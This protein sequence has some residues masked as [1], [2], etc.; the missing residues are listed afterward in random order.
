[1]NEH[2]ET[3]TLKKSTIWKAG[4][5]VFAILFVISLFTGGFGLGRTSTV[6][7]GAIVNPPAAAPAP[8]P[9]PAA[10]VNAADFV[11]DDP[12]LGKENA[13]VTIVEFS[14][15][16]CPFCSRFR[17][18]TFDQIKSQYIDTGKVRF[19]Y[20]DFPLT[21]IHPQAQK[22]AEASECADEQGKF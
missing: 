6:T 10:N 11:D 13:P 14:D 12:A 8:A 4:T 19:V 7:G 20:R 16:Q 1:M 5:A 15:F 22:A 2:E 3:V 18:E 17:T 21:S 9:L